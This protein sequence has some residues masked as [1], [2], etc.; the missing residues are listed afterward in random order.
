MTRDES[1][2]LKPGARVCFNDNPADCGTVSANQKWYVTIKWD[3]GHQSFSGH[4]DMNR[5]EL[6]AAK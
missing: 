1:S 5:V 2:K 6:A 3:D 4:N